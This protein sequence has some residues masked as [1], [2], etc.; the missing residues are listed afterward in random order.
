MWVTIYIRVP[1]LL[2][3]KRSTAS[4]SSLVQYFYLLLLCLPSELES[5]QVKLTPDFLSG[6]ENTVSL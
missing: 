3:A 2:G 4:F 6:K 5:I 1:H